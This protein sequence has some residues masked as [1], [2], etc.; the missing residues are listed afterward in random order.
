MGATVSMT[1]TLLLG[2]PVRLPKG[3]KRNVY[4][5]RLA[6]PTTPRELAD[7][8]HAARMDRMRSANIER[9]FDAIAAGWRTVL[10]VSVITGL[11][12][13]T[14]WKAMQQ[15]CLD[16]DGPPRVIRT[17]I[18]GKHFYEVAQ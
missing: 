8:T 3:R 17:N 11:S 15:L 2:L 13:V 10:H 4:G 7:E 1:A 16:C 14:C 5:M 12:H 6:A 9:V 18:N